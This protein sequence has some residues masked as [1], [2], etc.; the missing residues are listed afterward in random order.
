MSEFE[1]ST[2]VMVAMLLGGLGGYS[3]WQ[4]QRAQSLQ[5]KSIDS[6]H[7][8]S[9]EHGIESSHEAFGMSPHTVSD[10]PVHR[11]SPDEMLASAVH[12]IQDS[13]Q[14]KPVQNAYVPTGTGYALQ[15]ELD[16]DDD[17]Y[18][19]STSPVIS[20]TPPVYGSKS[21]SAYDVKPIKENHYA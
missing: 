13:K 1:L 14:Y 2:L 15:N 17:V 12:S 7:D 16:D 5:R 9:S 11:A 10:V 3:Y 19:R 21:N 18:V 6:A 8:Y 4:I 20:P